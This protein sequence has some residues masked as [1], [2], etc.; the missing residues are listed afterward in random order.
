MEKRV[1][2]TGLTCGTVDEFWWDRWKGMVLCR[3]IE[4]VVGRS[5]D[6]RHGRGVQIWC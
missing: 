4:W 6:F 2:H 1:E 5:D 3:L